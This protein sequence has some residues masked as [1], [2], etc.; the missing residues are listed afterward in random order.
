MT[1]FRI[2]VKRSTE[3]RP[4]RAWAVKRSYSRYYD[5]VEDTPGQPPHA[6][7]NPTG[8]VKITNEGVTWCREW[9]GEVAEAFKVAVAL[10]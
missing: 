5:Y 3:R 8:N 9:T 1:P 6:T 2:L 10:S 7:T 4:V